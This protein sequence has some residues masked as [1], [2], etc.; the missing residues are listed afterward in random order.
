M[1]ILARTVWLLSKQSLI[2][3]FAES[4]TTSYMIWL[5]HQMVVMEVYWNKNSNN[6]NQ[7]QLCSITIMAQRKWI[8][9]CEI[10]RAEL[11]TFRRCCVCVV[12]NVLKLSQSVSQSDF[13]VVWIQNV[14]GHTKHMRLPLFQL[15]STDIYKIISLM[16]IILYSI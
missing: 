16:L 13:F 15:L 10:R 4:S 6:G 5:H 14:Y 3:W 2:G 8:L 7:A 12:S 1:A 11:T 9:R